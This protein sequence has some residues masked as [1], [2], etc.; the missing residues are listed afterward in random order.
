MPRLV[1]STFST[2]RILV[3]LPMTIVRRIAA[4]PDAFIDAIERLAKR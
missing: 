1:A 3:K 4:S 2:V